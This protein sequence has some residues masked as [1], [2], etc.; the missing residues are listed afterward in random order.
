[1]GRKHHSV[2]MGSFTHTSTANFTENVL[3]LGSNNDAITINKPSRNKPL[4][5]NYHFSRHAVWDL[6]I[7]NIH[8]LCFFIFEKACF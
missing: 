1:M 4:K 2:K 7:Q 6:H 8:L 5:A 3:L